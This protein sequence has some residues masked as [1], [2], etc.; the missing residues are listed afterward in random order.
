M[1]M[2]HLHMGAFLLLVVGGLNWLLLGLFQWEIGSLFGGSDAVVSRVIYVLIGLA[3]VYE[4][5]THKKNC[6]GCAKKH[7]DPKDANVPPAEVSEV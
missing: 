3:A 2:K 6:K 5:A 7:E 1:N 4:L